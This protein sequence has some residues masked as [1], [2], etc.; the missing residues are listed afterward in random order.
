M[1]SPEILVEKIGSPL[2]KFEYLW[3]TGTFFVALFVSE[4]VDMQKYVQHK[5][6]TSQ[7]PVSFTLRSK[8]RK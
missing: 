2:E 4:S 1:G 3:P 5:K 8:Q 7:L 6:T